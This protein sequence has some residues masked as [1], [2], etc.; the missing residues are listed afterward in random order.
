[1]KL[2]DVK[3]SFPHVAYDVTVSHYAPRQATAVEWV[4]LEAIQA[5]TLDPGFRDAPSSA[6]FEEILSIKDADRLIKPVIFDLVGSGMMLVEGLSD[7]APLGKMLMS[8]FRLTEKGQKLRKDGILPART[9]ED[10]VHLYYDV[11]KETCEE[12]RERHLSPEATGVKVVEA[13]SADDIVF[14][15]AAITGYLESSRGRSSNPWLTKETHIQDL[16]ASGGKLLWK[17]ISCP[18]EVGRD[19]ICRFN[20]IESTSLSAKV[21]EQLDLPAAE[22]LQ[23]TVV[24]DP[25]VELNWLDSPKKTAPHVSE[26]LA[27]SNIGVIEADCFDE[28]AG[29]IDRGAL[30]GKALCIPSSG[31]FSARLENG[32]LLI[33]VQEDVLAEGAISLFPKETLRIESYE[34]RAG[35]ATRG[36][37]L[38]SSVPSAQGELESI[39]KEVATG[40]SGDSL[41][42]ALPLLALGE[43][44]LFQQIALD[45]L[46]NMKGLSQKSAAIEDAN[47]AA[48]VL[49]GSECITTEVARAALAE[50]LAR[51][52][53]G[54]AF[55]DIAERVAEVKSEC[56]PEDDG[57]VLDEAIAAGLRSL[58]EP[59]GVAQVWALWAS[60][61]E[62][63][64]DV[65][66]LGGD[67]VASL[68]SDRC[69]S[70]IMS[71]FDSADLYSLKAWT[72]IE[73]SILQLRR[74]CDGV[75]ALL[76]NADVYK[77]L[78]EEDARLLCIANKGSLAQ[79]YAEL[80]SWQQNLES[81]SGMGID[82]EEAERSDSPYAKASASM[83]SVVAG[84]RPFYDESALRYAAVYVV[85]T[86]ALMNSPELVET[87]EDNKALLIVPKVVLDELDGLKSSEDG[88]RAL[89]ARDAIRA[90]DNHRA[91]DWLN[92]RESGHP[93]LLS[94]DCDKDRNDSKI[95]SVAV[96]YIFK[97]PVLITDDSNLRNLAEANAVESIGSGDFLMARRESRIKKKRAKKKGGKR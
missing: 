19:L 72:V 52:F 84:I 3:L 18:F 89:K 76:S 70:E 91:F 85:D 73:R 26:L 63:G 11:I 61:D 83:K 86:C 74:S 23:S 88:E 69:L 15:T 4:I 77:P 24:T 9:M 28:L 1:M 25:D 67:V 87:F 49:F 12:G 51:V 20:G 65:S 71:A 6:I 45:A 68:Y 43:E 8:Q 47:H 29:I 78:T 97:K 41:L 13:E 92:L 39:C 80:K 36:A 16:A 21:L 17:N 53:S 95:L 94:D 42:A 79:V 93:E 35:N 44:D 14:P 27:S 60:L 81:L 33:E 64:I 22:G 31:G 82:L 30:R 59:S 90:I 56:S 38:L 66:S 96:R 32:A 5:S 34:L 37:T 7:E 10:V 46:A 50:E 54:C 40:H 58:P 55:D 62:R 48:K 75:S 2:A 57:R